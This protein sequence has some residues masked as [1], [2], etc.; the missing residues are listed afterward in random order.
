MPVHYLVLF[1]VGIPPYVSTISFSARL[2]GWLKAQC[3][4]CIFLSFPE[5]TEWILEEEY[6][7]K[8]TGGWLLEDDYWRKN[9]GGRIVEDEYWRMNTGGWILEEEYWSA[10]FTFLFPA[11][12]LQW[13][14]DSVNWIVYIASYIVHRVHCRVHSGGC[15][16]GPSVGMSILPSGC[17]HSQ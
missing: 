13:N 2:S 8:N 1:V 6:W 15:I 17:R 3:L 16:A 5:N 10:R 7:R 12:S 11:D 9:T 4:L 14:V